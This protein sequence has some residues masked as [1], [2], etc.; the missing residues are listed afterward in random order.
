MLRVYGEQAGFLIGVAL[1][2]F[3]PLGL[4]ESVAERYEEY[5]SEEFRGS[6]LAGAVAAVF[7]HVVSGSLGR[8]STPVW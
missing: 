2:V 1:L 7:V 4:V 6:E 8:G 3:V 5:E